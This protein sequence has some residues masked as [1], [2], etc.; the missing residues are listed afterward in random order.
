V[1]AGLR[2]ESVKRKP[3]G[4]VDRAFNLTSYSVGGLWEFM[5]GYGFGSTLSIAQRAPTPEELYSSGPHEATGTFDIGNANFAKESSRNIELTVQKTSGLVRWKANA[6]Q[7]RFKNYVYGTLTGN[8][9]DEEGNPGTDL[10]E[11]VFAQAN[12]TIRGAEAEVSYNSRGKG[13]S[14]RIFADASRGSI[15]SNGSLPL[16]P[17]NRFGLDAGY[18]S[19]AWR[20]GLTVLRVQSQDRLASFET[21]PTAGYTQV[22]LN[23]SYK[24][25]FKGQQL[26]WFAQVKNALNQDIRSSTSVLKDVAPQAGRNFVIGL[27]TLF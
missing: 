20:S 24:H 4:A 18:R 7:T 12:A 17:A 10:A 21:T 14:G 25:S 15:D 9:V 13:L 26:T 5:P 23:L 19:G 6:F 22:D 8:L 11:R 16:L 27:R 2:L 1:N 3:D